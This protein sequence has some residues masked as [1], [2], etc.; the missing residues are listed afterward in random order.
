MIRTF[1]R[2][3]GLVLGVVCALFY[4]S[5][6]TMLL[7]GLMNLISASYPEIAFSQA[8]EETVLF[9]TMYETNLIRIL[10]GKG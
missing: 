2:T 9:K 3:L 8:Y 7:F 4:A 1:D 6:Y 10:L 5:V